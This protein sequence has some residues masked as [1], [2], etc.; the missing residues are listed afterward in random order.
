MMKS[1]S[2]RWLDFGGTELSAVSAGVPRLFGQLL[3]L[4]AAVAA[5][6]V[7]AVYGGAVEGPT[8]SVLYNP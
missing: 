1:G 8:H 6:A 3:L 2:E 5:A 7:V 4:V